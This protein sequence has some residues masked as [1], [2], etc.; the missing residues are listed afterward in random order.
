M[1]GFVGGLGVGV[2]ARVTKAATARPLQ[3]EFSITGAINNTLPIGDL[4]LKLTDLALHL[5]PIHIPH[6]EASSARARA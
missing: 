4:V 5:A 2:S 1:L 6:R 3:P